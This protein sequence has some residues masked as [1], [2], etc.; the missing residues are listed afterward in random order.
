MSIIS[1]NQ[2]APSVGYFVIRE[3]E[4]IAEIEVQDAPKFE[5]QEEAREWIDKNGL[6][7]VDYWIC[8][9]MNMRSIRKI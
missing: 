3:Q 8:A 4:G 2:Y 7:G 5:S 9:P 6:R 1:G